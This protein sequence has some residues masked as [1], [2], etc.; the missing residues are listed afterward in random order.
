MM[1]DDFVNAVLARFLE[2]AEVADLKEAVNA[3][4]RFLPSEYEIDDEVIVL[5]HVNEKRGHRMG[6]GWNHE[7]TGGGPSATTGVVAE[8][9]FERRGSWMLVI[10]QGRLDTLPINV[11]G[12][13]GRAV[14]RAQSRNELD[15]IKGLYL[16]HG[17]LMSPM[18][19][20]IMSSGGKVTTAI[21]FGTPSVRA[22]RARI[23]AEGLSR[24]AESTSLL[25]AWGGKGAAAFKGIP[26]TDFLR[27]SRPPVPRPPTN[28]ND[29]NIGH[30]GSNS[31]S[32]DLDIPQPGAH[33][34]PGDDAA[35]T[36]PPAS[37]TSASA[38][39]LTATSAVEGAPI[40]EDAIARVSIDTTSAIDDAIQFHRGSCPSIVDDAMCVGSRPSIVE[41][42]IC[43]HRRPRPS[44]VHD[45]IQ[46]HR[47]PR[48]SIVDDALRFHRESH[49]SIVDDAIG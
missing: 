47:R 3:P 27:G 44:I 45:A 8:Y 37:T 14:R 1:P 48:P 25:Q 13:I 29:R 26:L 23:L 11:H 17:V 2:P 41:D 18:W 6:V 35:T 49:L 34:P 28:Q 15:A 16:V 31:V 4:P 36:S 10:S 19:K 40:S 30:H 9:T 22:S 7:I 5:S 46:F 21:Q 38:A 20:I 43:F 32:P 12:I 33:H 24:S 39:A 42:A